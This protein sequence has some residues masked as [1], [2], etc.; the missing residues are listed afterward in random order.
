MYHPLNK[1]GV[2]DSLHVKN[3]LSQL[4]SFTP[5]LKKNRAWR[6]THRIKK[7]HYSH[8]SRQKG[9]SNDTLR[10]PPPL[11]RESIDRVIVAA[12]RLSEKIVFLSEDLD[13][14]SSPHSKLSWLTMPGGPIQYLSDTLVVRSS[15]DFYIIFLI[16]CQ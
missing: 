8:L 6:D 10:V 1:G 9:R 14:S 13:Y 12:K 5:K 16:F 2:K 11:H 15:T 4:S 7:Y 3:K